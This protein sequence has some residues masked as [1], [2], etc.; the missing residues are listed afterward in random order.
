MSTLLKVVRPTCSKSTCRFGQ[1]E[2]LDFDFR[3]HCE[4]VNLIFFLFNHL[5]F[6]QN[7]I[8]FLKGV[9]GILCDRL[10]EEDDNLCLSHPCWNGNSTLLFTF[11]MIYS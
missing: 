2:Q 7:N 10:I 3:C 11:A 9:K 4:E 8:I 6:K 5:Y 1:C